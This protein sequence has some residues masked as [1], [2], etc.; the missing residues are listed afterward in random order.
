[1][2]DPTEECAGEF[3]T[4][5]EEA[6]TGTV[7]AKETASISELQPFSKY[8]VCFDTTNAFGTQQGPAVSFETPAVA[9]SI[10]AESSSAVKDTSASLES[11]VNP[12]NQETSFVWE[13]STEGEAGGA[14]TGSIESLPGEAPLSGFGDQP[15][16]VTAEGLLPRTTYF[17]RVVATNASAEK[18]EGAVQS[19][20]TLATPLVTIA[21]AQGVTRTQATLSGTVNPGGEPTSYHFVYVEAAHFNTGAEE[22]AVEPAS[23]CAYQGEG[24]RTTPQSGSV[25]SDYEAHPA[26]PLQITE[27]KPGTTYDYALVATNSLGTSVSAN[28]ELT[29]LPASPPAVTTGEAHGVSQNSATITGSVDT[30]GLPTT[31]SFQLG[32]T[33]GTGSLIAASAG[34]QSG[35]TVAISMSFSGILQPGTTYYYRAVATNADG[36]A[37]GAIQSFTTTTFPTPPGFTLTPGPSFIPFQ[38]IAELEAKEAKEHPVSKPPANEPRLAKAL[39]KCR[40]LHKKSNRKACE[41]Q[42]RKRY[43]TSRRGK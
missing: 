43:P 42:A 15:G 20:T 13:L 3:A 9:P 17:Y 2:A 34:E 40:K 12:N 38:S 41:R 14:L 10:D 30:R 32:T 36:T 8:T 7:E 19:F 21:G 28:Q 26:G 11:Q 22:C 23:L 33:P 31:L 24:S 6:G 29:T 35:T 4:P 25:G 39:R 37:E 16:N 1:V 18:S 5:L 27:L